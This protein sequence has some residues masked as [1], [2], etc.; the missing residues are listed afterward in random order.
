MTQDS[1]VDL[2]RLIDRFQPGD[3]EVR[4][5][6]LERAVDRLRRLAAKMLGESFPRL[7][8][9][10]DVD[11]VVNETWIRLLQALEQSSPATVQDFFRLAAHKIRQVL[12]DMADR[13]TRLDRREGRHLE[14]GDST[15]GSAVEQQTHDPLQ[16]TM[17]TE[18]HSRVP[19]LPDD[20]RQIFEMHYYL[21]IPQSE[22]A[23]ITGIAPRQVSRLWIKAIERLTQGFA[24]VEELMG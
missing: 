12:L 6:L 20:E 14:S 7:Q 23:R 9:E 10:H 19:K 18:F 24:A 5:E 2:Q 4:R 11:S 1:S 15:D 13:Q 3:L 22:I 16:L 8:G 17:W 21:E